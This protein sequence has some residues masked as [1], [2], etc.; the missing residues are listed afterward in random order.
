MTVIEHIFAEYA[1][2]IRHS[3]HSKEAY[4]AS[5]KAY[6][7][8]LDVFIAALSSEQKAAVLALEAQRNLI[9][10]MDEELMF[11][12]GFRI[13]TQLILEIFFNSNPNSE[14]WG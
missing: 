3:G 1:D 2:Y 8:G 5:L 11:C 14:N 9:A 4:D 7:D 10:A 12:E 13:G 6:A